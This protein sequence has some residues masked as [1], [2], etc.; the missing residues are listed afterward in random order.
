MSFY[1]RPYIGEKFRMDAESII[2]EIQEKL[3]GDIHWGHEPFLPLTKS[4]FEAAK[5]SGV[6][7]QRENGEWY[8]FRGFRVVILEKLKVYQD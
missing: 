4:M 3:N 5:Q 2:K 1:H 8:D 6:V 7:K